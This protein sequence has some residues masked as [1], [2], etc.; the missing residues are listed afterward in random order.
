MWPPSDGGK[1]CWSGGSLKESARHLAHTYPSGTVRALD[2][3]RSICGLHH[4]TWSPFGCSRWNT[5][6]NVLFQECIHVIIV[7]LSSRVKHQNQE[8]AHYQ[9][10]QCAFGCVVLVH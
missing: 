9:E 1:C 4:A 2:R 8:H 7:V 3:I 5:S 10:H 6:S